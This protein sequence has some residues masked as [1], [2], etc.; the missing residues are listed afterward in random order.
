MPSPSRASLGR[1]VSVGLQEEPPSLRME[2]EGDQEFPWLFV[3]PSR[4][5]FAR[6]EGLF[7]EPFACEP[8]PLVSSSLQEEPP[9]LRAER[10]G[11]Q[12]FPW[13]FVRPSRFLSA[14]KEGLFAEPPRVRA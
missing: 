12:E 8:R 3:R 13:L 14:R 5:L 11:D 4:I 10:E 6:K 9:S 2:R 7:A 1:W